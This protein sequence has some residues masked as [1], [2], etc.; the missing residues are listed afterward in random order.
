MDFMTDE[1]LI[2]KARI[3]ALRAHRDQMYGGGVPYSV[4]LTDVVDIL[5]RSAGDGFVYP[6][7][8]GIAA[9]WMHDVLEDTSL[10]RSD[11][12]EQFPDNVVTMVELVTRTPNVSWR[13]M[14]Q[15]WGSHLSGFPMRAE[16]T[17]RITMQAVRIKAADRLANCRCRPPA[18][19]REKYR[20]EN[21]QVIAMLAKHWR[22]DAVES[23][24]GR[25]AF[26]MFCEAQ[27]LLQQQ[28][29]TP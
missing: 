26:D 24:G 10:T 7:A 14:V 21:E 8:S 27:E 3:L 9:A 12:R 17:A 20:E 4:H 25:R 28:A 1:A 23:Y 19:L 13:D 22:L 15:R 16:A 11:L 29:Q 6:N 5:E 2:R 18:R